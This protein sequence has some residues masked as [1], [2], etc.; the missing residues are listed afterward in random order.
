MKRH[1]RSASGDGHVAGEGF[2]V[3]DIGDDVGALLLYAP[4]HM[5]DA[6]IEIT[7]AGDPT[8]RQHVAVHAR[9]APAGTT[10]AAVY[11]NLSAGCYEL[12]TTT[13]TV[14]LT[15]SIEGG[16]VTEAFWPEPMPPAR[17]SPPPG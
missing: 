15:V 6:E 10:Y 7:P 4:P 9:A 17:V 8:R 3:L 12:W 2:A 16:S 1:E 11:P 5:V 13:A 14:A